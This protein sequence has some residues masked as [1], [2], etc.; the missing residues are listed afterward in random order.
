MYSLFSTYTSLRLPWPVINWNNRWL[1]ELNPHN[2]FVILVPEHHYGQKVASIILVN[3]IWFSLQL[4]QQAE[5]RI[6]SWVATTLNT[7]TTTSKG[8]T[9]A[10]LYK[11][12]I[13]GGA[14]AILCN[15]IP[16]QLSMSAL[17]PSILL[18]PPLSAEHCTKKSTKGDVYHYCTNT[19]STTDWELLKM[20]V[21]GPAAATE[22]SF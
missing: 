21:M 6:Q 9:D 20:L 16:P 11:P 19:T 17:V 5:N 15:I 12:T 2:L 18:I 7:T 3:S 13:K 14:S 22:A 8:S 4:L 1:L 10:I